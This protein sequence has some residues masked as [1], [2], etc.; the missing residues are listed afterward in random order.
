MKKSN[1]YVMILDVDAAYEH[2]RD[3]HE[4]EKKVSKGAFLKMIGMSYQTAQNYQEGVSEHK[5]LQ[6]VEKIQE[7]TGLS[8]DE[9]I[10]KIG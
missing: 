6:Y 8:K 2:Y 9:L 1:G 3:N 10:K 5:I 4:L 7:V